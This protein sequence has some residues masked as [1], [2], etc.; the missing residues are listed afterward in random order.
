[1][2]VY[3]L[4]EVVGPGV[5]CECV[6]ERSG[7]HVNEDHFLPEIV[8]PESGEPVP[9][10]GEGV[11]VFTTLTKE[12][13]PVLRY[14]TGDICT[15]DSSPCSCGRT[16]VRMGPIVGRSD[17]MLIVRGVNVFP[18]Q[19]GAVLGRMPELSPHFGL[20]VRRL[21]TL[22]EV[23]VLAEVSPEVLLTLNDDRARELSERAAALIRDT[24]GCSMAVTLVEPGK[25]PRSDGGKIERV[26]DLR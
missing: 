5:S 11:L 2:N 21:G 17:D 22:D 6:E 14:W 26:Q 12:A 4:S 23:E 8:D 16:L 1:V 3:G 18:S 15:L 10:G 20:V 25:A 19:V 13:L 9:E 24:I 7:S